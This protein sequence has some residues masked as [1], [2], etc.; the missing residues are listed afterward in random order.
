MTMQTACNHLRRWPLTRMHGVHEHPTRAR[1]QKE[2]TAMF[3]AVA[4]KTGVP[5]AKMRARAQLS[6]LSLQYAGPTA[7]PK[8]PPDRRLLL[9]AHLDVVVRRRPAEGIPPWTRFIQIGAAVGDDALPPSVQLKAQQVTMGMGGQ[10]VGTDWAT[11]ENDEVIAG[12]KHVITRIRE[13]L[14][15]GVRGGSRRW[16]AD[17]GFGVLQQA[18]G[19]RLWAEHAV[20]EE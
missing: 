10:M 15:T 16:S 20:I 1:Q 6:E 2:L 19:R 17:Q 5:T 7:N 8:A 13:R 4:F 18:G 12:T 14:H 11:V 9:G 3:D